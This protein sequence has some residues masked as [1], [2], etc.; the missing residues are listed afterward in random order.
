MFLIFK[1]NCPFKTLQRAFET[2]AKESTSRLV[3]IAIFK[4]GGFL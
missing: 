3:E 2:L 4:C 1:V